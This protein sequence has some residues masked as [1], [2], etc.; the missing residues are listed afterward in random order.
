MASLPIAQWQAALDQM[1]LA[2]SA[3]VRSLDRAE[4][5]WERPGAP[6]AGEA[7]LPSALG[8]IDARLHEWDAR[9]READELT[10]AVEKELSARAGE[11]ERW[12]ALFARWRELLQRE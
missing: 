2:L 6:S 5:R 4:A 8:R 11:V 1:E 10:V 9:L 7:A 12:S 3:T